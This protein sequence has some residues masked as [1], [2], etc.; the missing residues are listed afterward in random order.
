MSSSLE[1][2]NM[3]QGVDDLNGLPAP[4]SMLPAHVRWGV[5]LLLISIAVGNLTGR[6]LSVNSVDKLQ[7][8]AAK[9]RENLDRQHKQ[10]IKEG[11]TGEQFESRMAAEATRL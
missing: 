3:R 7:L 4:C 10:L 8:E 5:Y 9:L 2:P 1:A 11:V 6:L